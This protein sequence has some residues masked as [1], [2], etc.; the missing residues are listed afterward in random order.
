MVAR[1][2]RGSS[3]NV[4]HYVLLSQIGAGPDGTA[5]RGREEG[6]GRLAEVR[7]LGPARADPGRWPGLVKRVRTATLID[8]PSV[9]RVLDFREDHD[10][11]YLAMEFSETRRLDSALATRVPLP[12]AEAVGLALAL[13]E[14]VGEAHRLGLAHGAIRPESIRLSD[15]GVPRIDFTGTATEAPIGPP[16][17]PSD[18][19]RGLGQVLHWLLVGETAHDL[20]SARLVSEETF[21]FLPGPGEPDPAVTLDRLVSELL[22]PA[23]SD[24][25]PIREAV[26]RLAKI[27]RAMA[28]A[29]SLATIE[30]SSG[31]GQSADEGLSF[32]L[33]PGHSGDSRKRGDGE[34]LGVTTGD[35]LGRYRLLEKL[36]QG[37]M[38]AVFRGEDMAD[39]AIVAVKVLRPE[40]ATKPG[41]FRRFQKEARLLGE[42]NNPF[43]TNLLEV[44]EDRGIHFLVLEYV[45]GTSLGH[46]L[47]DRAPMEEAEAVSILSDV[48]RALVDAHRRGIVHRDIKPDN[49][50]LAEADVEGKRRVK[51]SDFGLARHVVESHSLQVTQAQAVVGTPTYMAPEQGMATAIDAR[52]DVYSM[53]VT[54]F[55]MLAGR[56]PFQAE[57][58][59]DMIAL[60]CNEPPPPLSRFN[61]KVSEGAARIVVKALAKAPDSATPTPRPS[62][63]T[64]SA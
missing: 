58:L 16:M 35:V 30:S 1:G 21:E 20:S 27:A 43:V 28:P 51:L 53:G 63:K 4:G 45:S 6:Q 56:P 26:E 29:S 25:P 49:I 14:G 8:H 12:E 15:L 54:L 11:P 24:R 2:V 23:S 9:I 41:A 42:V 64:S 22:A 32:S 36:G 47:A 19:V 61:P 44:N 10:P 50:L 60:H 7:L 59:L 62:S 38:G 31:G 57:R 18:D 13:A 48:A 39:G 37:G 3:M 17:D 55:H 52:T 46:A 40:W 33:R 5:Y 34:P